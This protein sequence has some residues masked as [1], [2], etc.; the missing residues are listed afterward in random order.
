MAPEGAACWFPKSSGLPPPVPSGGF[1]FWALKLERAGLREARSS[2]HFKEQSVLKYGPVGSRPGVPATRPCAPLCGLG[3][4]RLGE[5][6][7][8]W[9]PRR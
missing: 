9:A 4:G 5:S 1:V 7:P 8:R 6:A 3:R 2:D